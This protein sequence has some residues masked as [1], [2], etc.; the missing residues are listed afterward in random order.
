MP[1]GWL[2]LVGLSDYREAG[3]KF[4]RYFRDIG[5]L[6]P[7][8]RVLDV[9]SGTGRMA[10]PL[11]K[12]LEGGSYDGLDI[13]AP[14]VEWCRKTYTPR[15]PNFHFHHADVHNSVYNPAGACRASEYRF[16]FADSYFDFIFLTSVFTHMLPDDM[17]NYLSEIA[18]VLK[19]GGRCFITYFLL[20]PESLRLIDEKASL[21]DFRYQLP[22]CRIQ[23]EELPEAAVAYDESKIRELYRV[24]KLDILEPI[25]YGH[26][27]GRKGG[28]SIQEIVA[29]YRYAD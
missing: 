9:G 15:Y 11:T 3:E 5:G 27:C 4:F 29:A 14:S 28:L 25:Y 8:E 18:R 20:T 26:W 6:K 22:G 23:A 7:H 2:H 24:F 12:Y 10:R 1:P 13:V 17:E 21:F 16:P 19:P